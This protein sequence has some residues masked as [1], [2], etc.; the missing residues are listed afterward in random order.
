M[1]ETIMTAEVMR[2]NNHRKF[3][4]VLR[5]GA[6]SEAAPSWLRGKYHINLGGDPYS[7][8]DYEDLVR[9]LLGIRETAPPIGKPMATI[10]TRANEE[11]D[12]PQANPARANPF[13]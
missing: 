12:P 2:S 9:T 1:R 4:P 13:R 10:G 11:S 7:E 5:K 8:R 3:I 6:W